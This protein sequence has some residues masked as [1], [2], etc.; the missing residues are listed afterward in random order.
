MEKILFLIKLE[1]LKL[2]T[3]MPFMVLMGMYVVLLPLFMSVGLSINLPKQLGDAR[4]FYMFP[5]VWQ[6]LGYVGNWLCYFIMGFIAVLTVTNEFSN[7]TLRQ[8]IISGVSRLDFY[9]SKVYFLFLVALGATA[10][11]VIVALIYGFTFTETVYASRVMDN[12]DMIPRYLLMIVT[13]MSFGLMLGVL[14]R[15]TGI[16]LFLYFAYIMFIE[17]IIR[18]LVI[19]KLFG[20]K[21]LLVY[22]PINAANDLTPFPFPKMVTT[23]TENADIKLFLSPTQA[24]VTAVVFTILFLY[25]AF[26]QLKTRDL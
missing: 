17:R 10:Y 1:W 15:K 21:D 3:Y 18:Y 16:A 26:Y 2:K 7:R 23:M 14:L 13:F 24:T 19:G 4:S 8:N 22:A 5:T 6:T 12:I 9:L 20:S 25:L 11:Y